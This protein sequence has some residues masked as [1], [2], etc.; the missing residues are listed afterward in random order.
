VKRFTM[1]E[2]IHLADGSTVKITAVLINGD[3][4]EKETFSQLGS[5]AYG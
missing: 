2:P 3:N 5:G 4:Q 1:A